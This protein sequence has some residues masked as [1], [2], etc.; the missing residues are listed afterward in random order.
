V[1]HFKGKKRH[2]F[3]RKDLI[4]KHT[5]PLSRASVRE[6]EE[7]EE[8]KT[9]AEKAP[10]LMDENDARSSQK[11]DYYAVLNLPR[12][13]T[14]EDVKRKYKLLAQKVHPDKAVSNTNHA[15]KK[16]FALLHEAYQ[17]LHDEEKRKVYDIYGH[18][19]VDDSTQSKEIMTYSKRKTTEEM[20]KEFEYFERQKAR[21]RAERKHQQSSGYEFKFSFAHALDERLRASRRLARGGKSV[22]ERLKRVLGDGGVGAVEG[23][24]GEEKQRQAL[25]AVEKALGD[26]HVEDLG[27]DFLQGS[28]STSMSATVSESLDVY[29]QAQ[30]MA[31]A[32][33]RGAGV[34]LVGARKQ[35]GLWT[36]ADWHMQMPSQRNG[37]M[38]MTLEQKLTNRTTGTMTCKYD[39]VGVGGSSA[40]EETEDVGTGVGLSVG[41][42]RQLTHHAVGNIDWNV[43][44]IPGITTGCRGKAGENGAWKLDLSAG[45]QNFGLTGSY[46]RKVVDG[47][48]ANARRHYPNSALAEHTQTNK[49]KKY[50]FK[51]GTMGIEI[52]NGTNATLSDDGE[53][54]IGWGV[55]VGVEGCVLKIKYR[56]RNQQ[57]EFPILLAPGLPYLTRRT[58][59]LCLTIPNAVIGVLRNVF[60][61][62]LLRRKKRFEK[63]QMRLRYA[64]EIE[65]N[66]KDAL[67]QRELV[68]KSAEEK[69][70]FER[71]IGGLD[72]EKAVYGSFENVECDVTKRSMTFP[73][74]EKE[75]DDRKNDD[76]ERKKKTKPK[77]SERGRQ[78]SD[79]LRDDDS[80]IDVTV[81]LRHMVERSQLE[82]HDGV[83][84]SSLLG[85]CD[86]DPLEKKHLKIRYRYRRALHETCVPQDVGIHLPYDGH[87]IADSFQTTEEVERI[88]TETAISEEEGEGEDKEEEGDV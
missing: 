50:S 31:N 58:A 47:S 27:L 25:R 69:R 60:I 24:E 53:T 36:S 43:G 63:K 7:E 82:L 86:V 2:N 44:P 74:E 21:E 61:L 18:V 16:S 72:I 28:V 55:C 10:I 34:L 81:A 76:D 88:S 12:D 9:T 62:P 6:Y 54:S 13:C 87:R 15:A 17:I 83:S 75:K 3:T 64:S 48:S 32:D 22:R 66:R 35:L 70:V 59:I 80:W 84:Y 33:G 8:S 11:K 38:E 68:A 42:K 39:F 19:G 73:D 4:R 1:R 79:I 37:G 71:E 30:A 41:L 65:E 26:F 45:V 67:A 29:C 14:T 85:F 49:I 57:F 52:E 78:H 46:Q 40:G 5:H 77:S 23:K 56:Q 51:F 20:R